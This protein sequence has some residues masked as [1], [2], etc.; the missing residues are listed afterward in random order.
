M[1]DCGFKKSVLD[2]IAR[3]NTL[4]EGRE[5]DI[6]KMECFF[7]TFKMVLADHGS[8]CFFLMK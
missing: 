6:S 3:Q 7:T 5:T 4:N 2:Q 8:G 1:A